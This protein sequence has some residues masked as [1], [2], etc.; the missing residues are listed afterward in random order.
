MGRWVR[1]TSGGESDKEELDLMEGIQTAFWAVSPSSWK[2]VFCS[3]M[4]VNFTGPG[5][6]V[7]S[8]ITCG[9]TSRI[10]DALSEALADTLMI[11][12]CLRR[13]A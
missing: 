4:E 3:M 13:L 7:A 1:R 6:K 10:T 5:M 9:Q 11:R 8:V 2:V 12:W